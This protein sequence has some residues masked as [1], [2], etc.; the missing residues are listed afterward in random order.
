MIKVVN[1]LGNFY[2]SPKDPNSSRNVDSEKIQM[3]IST[4]FMFHYSQEPAY[5]LSKPGDFVGD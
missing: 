3:G 5:T 2:G 4:V 1:M